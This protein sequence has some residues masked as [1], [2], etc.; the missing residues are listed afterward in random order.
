MVQLCSKNPLDF[1]ARSTGLG[2]LQRRD[3]AEV[4][5]EYC[6]WGDWE[7]VENTGGAELSQNWGKE[8]IQWTCGTCLFSKSKQWEDL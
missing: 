3:L 6:R 5:L 7:F 8:K 4:V 2:K 1:L